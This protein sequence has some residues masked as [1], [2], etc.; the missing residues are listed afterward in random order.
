MSIYLYNFSIKKECLYKIALINL[1]FVKK[2][3]NYYILH[4]KKKNVKSK[5]NLNL[6]I[7]YI[8]SN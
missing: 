3:I 4:I 7:Y 5:N 6:I 1:F 8:S 2:I